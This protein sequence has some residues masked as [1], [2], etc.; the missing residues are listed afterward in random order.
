MS[1]R[2]LM[3]GALIAATCLGGCASR[4]VPPA[5]MSVI[6]PDTTLSSLG[7]GDTLGR[8]IYINDLIIAAREAN[9]DFVI[10]EVPIE[11]PI[12]LDE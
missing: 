9:E 5:S 4:R 2:K 10:T 12:R 6:A 11:G 7:A 3:I 1:G 8:S